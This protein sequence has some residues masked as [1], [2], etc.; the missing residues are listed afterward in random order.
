MSLKV[1]KRHVLRER[2]IILKGTLER[3]WKGNESW[4]G[5]VLEGPD[6]ISFLHDFCCGYL[7]GRVFHGSFRINSEV[8]V[9]EYARMWPRTESIETKG[10]MLCGTMD[11]LQYL[12]VIPAHWWLRKE[13]QEANLSCTFNYVQDFSQACQQVP[14]L[15]TEKRQGFNS[16]DNMWILVKGFVDRAGKGG[17]KAER[18]CPT[19]FK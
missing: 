14:R 3:K 2:E 19:D 5:H 10:K 17:I 15:P 4:V 16:K 6:Q 18:A 13:D 9:E 12:S 7:P 1:K 8:G 11:S